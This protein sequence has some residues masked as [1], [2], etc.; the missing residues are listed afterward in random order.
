M[1]ITREHKQAMEQKD[2]SFKVSKQTIFALLER[3]FPLLRSRSFL[4]VPEKS[5]SRTNLLQTVESIYRDT[6]PFR[7]LHYNNKADRDINKRN[8]LAR[9]SNDVNCASFNISGFIKYLICIQIVRENNSVSRFG[10]RQRIFIPVIKNAQLVVNVREIPSELS[11]THICSKNLIK[12][13]SS[14][15]IPSW[16]I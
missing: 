15:P 14:V 11:N 3:P 13:A 5:W 7:V 1:A 12:T 6:L 2:L 16:N 8:I 9:G 10:P 4:D